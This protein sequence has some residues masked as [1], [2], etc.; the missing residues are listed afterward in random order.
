MMVEPGDLD[1]HPHKHL[2]EAETITILVNRG[3]ARES[4]FLTDDTGAAERARADGIRTVTTWDL[5]K[6]AHRVKKD[7]APLL[8]DDDAWA[9]AQELDR[10]DRRRWPC[11]PCSKGR[12]VFLA[13]LKK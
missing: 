4:F 5:L 9:A 12:A 3:W 11:P 2:G 6:L 13:W 8:T 1:D 7:N 10:Q